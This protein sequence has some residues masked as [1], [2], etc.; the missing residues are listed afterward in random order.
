MANRKEPSNQSKRQTETRMFDNDSE[1][2]DIRAPMQGE[3]FA[4][5]V[6][7]YRDALARND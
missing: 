5:V 6:R 4:T 7:N 3:E 1:D 2:S